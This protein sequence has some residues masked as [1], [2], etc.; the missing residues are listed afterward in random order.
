MT[1]LESILQWAKTAAVPVTP[2][3]GSILFPVEGKN[4]SWLAKVSALEEDDL[5]FIVTAYPFHV[6]ETARLAAA[7]TL[8]EIT[9]QIKLG[10]FYLDHADGQINFRLG[11]KICSGEE[12]AQWVA[13]WIMIAM[14]VTDSYYS[15]MT[16]LAAVH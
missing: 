7:V 5:L 3:D 6:S 14:Q 9:S 15:K 13:E 1:I 10:A 11:Q 4:G 12:R 8:A 2:E 16:A